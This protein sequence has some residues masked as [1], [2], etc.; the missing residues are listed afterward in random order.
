MSIIDTRVDNTNQ[1]ALP[2]DALLVQ[3]FDPGGAVG[4]VVEV[5]RVV[6]IIPSQACVLERD[7]AVVPGTF[8]LW[9]GL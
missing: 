6:G 1:C 4:R 9:Q 2:Q 8:N 3:G 7:L 5:D